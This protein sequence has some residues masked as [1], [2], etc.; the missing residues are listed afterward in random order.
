M[1]SSQ[2][3]RTAL[4]PLRTIRS[5]NPNSAAPTATTLG[6]GDSIF[7]LP[8]FPRPVWMSLLPSPVVPVSL[9]F[10][11]YAVGHEAR[12]SEP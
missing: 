10:P 8:S 5:T 4:L 1:V 6:E 2:L 9:A 3:S 11:F 7:G 12:D